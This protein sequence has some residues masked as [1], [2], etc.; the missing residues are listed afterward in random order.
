MKPS[1]VN[2]KRA[3]Q[4]AEKLIEQMSKEPKPIRY[5]GYKR[6]ATRASEIVANQPVVQEML[7]K[8]LGI[9]K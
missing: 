8:H 6:R 2:S 5:P 4:M 9:K 7:S 1:S 3:L